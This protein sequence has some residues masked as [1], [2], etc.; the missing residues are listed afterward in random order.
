MPWRE[1]SMTYRYLDSPDLDGRFILTTGL[2]HNEIEDKN[3]LDLN[4][5]TARLLKYLP[6]TYNN[7]YCND[8]KPQ[9]VYH[10]HGRVL[11]RRLSDD[12]LTDELISS[13]IPIDVLLCFG[14][15]DGTKTGTPIESNT[16]ID[17]ITRLTHYKQP[18]HIILEASSRWEYLYKIIHELKHILK[19]EGYQVMGEWIITPPEVGNVESLT[20]RRL[21][22]LKLISAGHPG[23]KGSPG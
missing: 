3:I 23:A 4:C 2:L 7:Y 11:F 18:T 5:G 1:P 22:H 6:H 9:S 17:S 12:V 21:C 14:L 19:K 15:V 13:Y 16:L 8:I 20:P 10:P